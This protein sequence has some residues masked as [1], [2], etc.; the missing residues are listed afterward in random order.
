MTN[1]KRQ[2]RLV[3][4]PCG[5]VEYVEAK[6][7]SA[8]RLVSAPCGEVSVVKH[9]TFRFRRVENNPRGE[10]NATAVG[11]GDSTNS[12]SNLRECQL[13]GRCRRCE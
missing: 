2:T 6:D 10:E 5:E 1:G 11:R 9:R 3:S 7:S 8:E 13:I 12:E 4:A